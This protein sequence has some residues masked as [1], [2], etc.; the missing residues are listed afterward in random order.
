MKSW[1]SEWQDFAS[2][3]WIECSGKNRDAARTASCAGRL[4]GDV[5]NYWSNY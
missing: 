1:L 4:A 5:E 3:K 2:T